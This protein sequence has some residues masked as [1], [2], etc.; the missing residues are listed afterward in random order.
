MLG[1]ATRSASSLPFPRRLLLF[2]LPP[3]SPLP[4]GAELSPE[5]RAA[6]RGS[7]VGSGPAPRAS[8][9][10]GQPLHQRRGHW[11]LE[12]AECDHPGHARGG[13]GV[14]QVRARLAS[15]PSSG[16]WRH[17]A[18]APGTTT[19]LGAGEELRVERGH[20]SSGADA[21]PHP[22]PRQMTQSW[23]PE[24]WA[25]GLSLFVRFL[26]NAMKVGKAVTQLQKP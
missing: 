9:R 23:G 25:L 2:P 7:E 20:P 17:L 13:V 1:F 8:A 18:G 11:G 6:R 22:P 26:G 24:W 15:L 12:P 19:R 14:L 4:V 21:T 16:A 10:D 5:Q 3:P